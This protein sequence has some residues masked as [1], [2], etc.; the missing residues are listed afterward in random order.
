MY[1][2]SS[3]Y[4]HSIADKKLK[5]LDSFCTSLESK[6]WKRK[7]DLAI[8]LGRNVFLFLRHFPVSHRTNQEFGY[9]RCLQVQFF[10]PLKIVRYRI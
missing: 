9:S 5:S 6:G 3:S 2:V 7:N 8:P 1:N 4:L 10:Y